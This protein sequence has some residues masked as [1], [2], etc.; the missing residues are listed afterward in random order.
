MRVGAYGLWRTMCVRV[1]VCIEIPQWSSHI[2][3]CT[4]QFHNSIKF[5]GN[6]LFDKFLRYYVN[7]YNNTD[8]ELRIMLVKSPARTQ[9]RSG[10]FLYSLVTSI[11]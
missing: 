8:V 2:F 3:N 4:G 9:D 6:Y 10:I 7:I 1:R 5:N 11:I